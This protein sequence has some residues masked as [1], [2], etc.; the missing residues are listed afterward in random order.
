MWKM[1]VVEDRTTHSQ[2]RRPVLLPGGLVGMDHA[3]LAQIAEQILHH[4]LAG[5]AD[6]PDA[7]VE[8]ANRE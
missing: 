4:R 3:G 8:R 7:A 2:R 5:D 6:L 1:A